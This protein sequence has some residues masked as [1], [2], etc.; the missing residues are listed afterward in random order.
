MNPGILNSATWTA[1]PTPRG[2]FGSSTP[3]PT[4][5]DVAFHLDAVDWQQRAVANGGS[6]S[7]RTLRAVSDLCHAINR[8]GLRTK[9]YRM[10]WFVGDNIAAAMTPLFLGPSLL[11]RVST[12]RYDTSVNFVSADFSEALGFQ[13]NGSGKR[14]VSM[15]TLSNG[16]AN[17]ANGHM[18]TH[19][20]SYTSGSGYAYALP[21]GGSSLD[22]TFISNGTSQSRQ[23]WGNGTAGEQFNFRTVVGR[24]HHVR[25][26]VGV[27]GRFVYYGRFPQGP[28]TTD[29][30]SIT[31]AANSL[32]LQL[33]GGPNQVGTT[34][35]CSMGGYSIGEPLTFS[36]IINYEAAMLPFCKAIGRPSGDGSF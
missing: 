33:M 1:P 3:I 23:C 8:G 20:T 4:P 35:I 21:S 9:F 34:A 27:A 30:T 19:I 28:N 25:T 36:E 13:T 12:P 24:W 10:N 6:V 7:A 26:I 32:G 15:P 14:V 16:V 11:G 31:P 29:T 17:I 5:M 18:T 22:Q 2:L